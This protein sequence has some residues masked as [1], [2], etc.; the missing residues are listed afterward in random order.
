MLRSKFISRHASS[1]DSS[2]LR[3]YSVPC[4][5][6]APVPGAGATAGLLRLFGLFAGPGVNA[7]HTARAPIAVFSAS[8]H[9]CVLMPS[10]YTTAMRAKVPL[11][12]VSHG[13]YTPKTAASQMSKVAVVTCSGPNVFPVSSLSLPLFLSPAGGS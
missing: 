8:R 2:P 1:I 13:S 5:A 12:G 10:S 6:R 11:K 7:Q 9:F 3:S 4:D